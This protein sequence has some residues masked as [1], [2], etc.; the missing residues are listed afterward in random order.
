M[1]IT[2]VIICRLASFNNY[3]SIFISKKE[4]KDW[5]FNL[6]FYILYF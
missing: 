4:M 3:L 6:I 1:Y 5:I 2:E